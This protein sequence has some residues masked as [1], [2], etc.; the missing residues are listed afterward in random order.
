ME[1]VDATFDW[2]LTSHQAARL[3]GLSMRQLDY[4]ARQKLVVPCQPSPGSG[5]PRRWGL[6]QV[7]HL[8]LAAILRDLGASE[9]T[10]RP[11]LTRAEKMNEQAWS[12]R[13]VVMADGRIENLLS[14]D[15]DGYLVDLRQCLDAAALDR[16]LAA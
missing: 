11:A 14:S 1:A 15:A 13:M 2:T 16:I 3:A 9:E 7:K 12:S 4:L 6:W 5:V 8:R 10:M